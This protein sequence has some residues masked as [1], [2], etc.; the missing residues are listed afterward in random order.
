MDVFLSWEKEKNTLKKPTCAEIALGAAQAY[1][2]LFD[3]FR[4]IHI[5]ALI[6]YISTRKRLFFQYYWIFQIV[7]ES[8]MIFSQN[9]EIILFSVI[10]NSLCN[11]SQENW[12]LKFKGTKV[13]NYHLYNSFMWY[14]GYPHW[15]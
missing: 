7:I 10:H 3:I 15:D 2:A 1:S 4:F 11:I 5:W 14:T 9:I 6:K 13:N 12:N 8:D